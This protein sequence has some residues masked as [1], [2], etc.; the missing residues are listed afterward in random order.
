MAQ[1]RL[2][3]YLQEA[4]ID[5]LETEGDIEETGGTGS[6]GNQDRDEDSKGRPARQ[7]KQARAVKQAAH[8]VLQPTLHE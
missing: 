6:R 4:S 8:T 2:P 1:A 5:V 3:R 7:T